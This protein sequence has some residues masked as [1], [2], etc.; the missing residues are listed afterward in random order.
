[1][2]R[3][4][5]SIAAT[6]ALGACSEPT[7]GEFPPKDDPPKMSENFMFAGI[8]YPFDGESTGEYIIKKGPPFTFNNNSPVEQ[9]YRYESVNHTFNSSEFRSD[10]K[11]AFQ[12]VGAAPQVEVPRHIYD[13]GIEV[14]SWE[15][16]YT[17]GE[18]RR[19]PSTWSV[20]DIRIPPRNTMT[21][22]VTYRYK[23]LGA[24]YRLHL[25]GVEQGEEITVEGL[26]SGLFL[27]HIDTGVKMEPL[28]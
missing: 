5:L 26:W 3:Y 8:E 10:D 19:E 6:L 9:V 16:P 27:E 13:A 20:S 7:G 24:R 1:M 12:L 17:E 4:I 11:R 25:M 22:N 18:Q 14:G 23:S 2:K 21:L 15:W 28:D